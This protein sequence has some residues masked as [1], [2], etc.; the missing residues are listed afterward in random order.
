VDWNSDSEDMLD[1]YNFCGT[2]KNYAAIASQGSW[3]SQA[4]SLLKCHSSAFHPSLV[5]CV[6]SKY[7]RA[8]IEVNM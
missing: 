7:E 1:S 2:N 6:F 4:S 3:H 5:Y 8:A